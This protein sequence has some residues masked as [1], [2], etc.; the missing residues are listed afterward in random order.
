MMN[1]NFL[2]LVEILSTTE[3][4]HIRSGR[5]V[6]IPAKHC[7]RHLLDTAL[8]EAGYSS[9]T[10]VDSDAIVFSLNV[11]S[12]KDFP[13]I[14]K[15]ESTFWEANGSAECAP[16]YF[17]IVS[18]SVSSFDKGAPFVNSVYLV[19][20]VRKLI[21][22]VADHYIA[23]D[24]KALFFVS[25]EGKGVKKDVV[26]SLSIDDVHKIKFEKS[27]LV[28]IDELFNIIK[29]DDVHRS[30]R[31][32][33]FRRALTIL[34]EEPHGDDPDF[35]W[36]INNIGRLH[37]KYK[38][39]YEI[40]FHN[41]SVSKLLNE[42][43]QKSLEFT[44]KLME[45][46]SSSQNKALSIPSAIIAIAALV[47]IG[48]VWEV[49]LVVGG[50]WL[51]KQIVIMSNEAMSST[52]EDLKNQV[53]KSFEK[54]KKIKDSSEVVN[55]AADN[56]RRLIKKIEDAERNLVKINKLARYTFFAGLVYALIVMFTDGESEKNQTDRSDSPAVQ[57]ESE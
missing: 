54:Y 3:G 31:E 38:E 32:E 45:F 17:Y 33:V 8:S 10:Q 5:F 51:V 6:A 15:D 27:S 1:P 13:P 36:T 37:R 16:D 22:K 43:D 18:S 24:Q 30:E 49:I 9:V 40:Y 41:F 50:L 4:V 7:E 2:K 53:D 35:L 34:L 55:L 52:F 39:Q 29:S 20:K 19:F 46:V 14:Y 48:G 12:W 57:T 26:L 11:N 47:R 28:S 42:I 23:S 25:D 56:R 21:S 44:S